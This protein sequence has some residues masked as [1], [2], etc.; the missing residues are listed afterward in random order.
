MPFNDF[1]SGAEKDKELTYGENS[2]SPLFEIPKVK[3]DLATNKTNLLEM[4]PSEQSV[5]CT[6]NYTENTRSQQIQISRRDW[7]KLKPSEYLNDVLILFWLKFYQYYV[8]KPLPAECYV[9]D[10]QFY[11]KMIGRDMH[12]NMFGGFSGTQQL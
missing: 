9:F 4:Y 12:S 3:L 10:P 8:Y 5:I 7:E 2:M 11:S 6:L 1:D